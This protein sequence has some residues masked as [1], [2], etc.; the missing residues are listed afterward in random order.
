MAIRFIKII[1]LLQNLPIGTQTNI[2]HSHLD[3]VD[4]YISLDGLR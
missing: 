1:N 3:N 2:A 4:V